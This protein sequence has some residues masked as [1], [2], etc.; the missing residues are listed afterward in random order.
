MGSQKDHSEPGDGGIISEGEYGN[1]EAE[2]DREGSGLGDV[3]EE[4]QDQ[5]SDNQAV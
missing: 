5:Y 3:D 4:G 2:G 1:Y